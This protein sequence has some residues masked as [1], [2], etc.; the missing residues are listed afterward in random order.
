MDTIRLKLF[1]IGALARISARRV[2]LE[3][4]STYLWKQIY[5]IAFDA[6]RC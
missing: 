2:G 1:E 4:S 5:A 3:L 6:V